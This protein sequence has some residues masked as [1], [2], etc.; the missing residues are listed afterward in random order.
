MMSQ[1]STQE[2]RSKQKYY[3][4]ICDLIFISSMYKDKHMTGKRH[5]NMIK[6]YEL[7]K[8][9]DDENNNSNTKNN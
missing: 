2:E 6:A 7:Q 9:L 8:E 1:H 5:A 4:V 3:C